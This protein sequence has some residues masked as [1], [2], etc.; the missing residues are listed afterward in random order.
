MEPQHRWVDDPEQVFT[1]LKQ[2][3]KD[4]KGVDLWKA[5]E[6]IKLPKECI[7]MFTQ[8]KQSLFKMLRI[9][10][11]TCCLFMHCLAN[12]VGVLGPYV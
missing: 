1:A 8:L 3:R 10:I 9:L 4:P 12:Q 6:L 11:R 2:Y 7:L 5:S